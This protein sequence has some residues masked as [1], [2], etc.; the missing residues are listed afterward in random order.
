MSLAEAHTASFARVAAQ[1]L[2]AILGAACQAEAQARP[3][4]SPSSSRDL[5]VSVFFTGMAFGEYI[6]AMEEATALGLLG[7]PPETVGEPEARDEL[8][9]AFAEVLNTA[10]GEAITE[11]RDAYRKLTFTAP[12]VS[13]GPS[14]YPDVASA[15]CIVHTPAGDVECRFYLDAMRLDL[16]TSYEEVVHA[17]VDSNRTLEA[18][19]RRLQEQQSQLVHAE[20]MASLGVLAAGVAHEINNPLAFVDSNLATLDGYLDTLISLFSVYERLAESLG[21][22]GDDGVREHLS[23]IGEMQETEDLRFI[24]ED[25]NTLLEDSKSGLDRIKTIIRSL[26][27]FSHVDGGEQQPTDLNKVIENTL[28][29]VWNQIKY[30]CEVDRELTPIPDVIGNP[31]EFGQVFTNLLINAAQAMQ[32]SGRISVETAVEGSEVVARVRDDGCGIEAE[33]LDRIFTPFFTTKPVGQ[34]TGLGLSIS[35]GIVKKHGGR[36]EVESTPGVGT[37]FTLRLPAAPAASLAEAS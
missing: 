4:E 19:N 21:H 26:K 20:K 30:T 13:H 35:Y 31:S 15:V 28:V 7:M 29:L 17:L 27:E 34:G 1:S 16:A 2:T 3:T 12:R 32:G 23:R 14:R 10:V 18:A 6:L 33:H 37:T 5:Q 11:L 9:D 36:L 8:R 25:T 22:L 24:I